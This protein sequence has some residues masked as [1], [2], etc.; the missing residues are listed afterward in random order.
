M[1]PPHAKGFETVCVQFSSFSPKV[2]FV[3][4]S[5]EFQTTLHLSLI[6]RGSTCIHIHRKLVGDHSF[7]ENWNLYIS[8]SLTMESRLHAV[9]GKRWK[10]AT[11]CYVLANITSS[12]MMREGHWKFRKATKVFSQRFEFCTSWVLSW[13]A[14]S[15]TCRTKFLIK[16]SNLFVLF[17]G[18][19]YSSFIDHSTSTEKARPGSMLQLNE[20]W[21]LLA[22][23][24]GVDPGFGSRLGTPKGQ[25]LGHQIWSGWLSFSH[26]SYLV[27]VYE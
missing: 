7:L 1:L 11:V 8:L 13:H 19:I 21:K 20:L 3:S 18:E 24:A 14:L 2:I 26:S 5:S 10:L 17:F 4:C 22:K 27:D 6:E 23:H 15:N 9:C 16:F 12:A 25:K